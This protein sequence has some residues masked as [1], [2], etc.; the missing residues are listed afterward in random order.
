MQHRINKLARL[1]EIDTR[2]LVPDK[3]VKNTK[4]AGQF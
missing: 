1:S 2:F 3:G 4:K